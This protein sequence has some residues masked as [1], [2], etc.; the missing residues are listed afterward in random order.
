M[1]F[2]AAPLGVELPVLA[3]GM[4]VG[5]LAMIKI[6]SSDIRDIYSENVQWLREKS[7]VE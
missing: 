4:G 6:G 7:M 2:S 1:N 3:F 5:R